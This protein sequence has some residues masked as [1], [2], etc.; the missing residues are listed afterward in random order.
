MF[1]ELLAV[2]GYEVKMTSS[3]DIAKEAEGSP[4][5]SIKPE[6]GKN[7][8]ESGDNVSAPV[9]YASGLGVGGTEMAGKKTKVLKKEKGPAAAATEKTSSITREEENQCESGSD[10]AR[11]KDQLIYLSKIIGFKV[12]FVD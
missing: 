4:A 5:R 3:A 12:S 9:V 2:L 11:P 8:V 10:G 1:A 7:S 6:K